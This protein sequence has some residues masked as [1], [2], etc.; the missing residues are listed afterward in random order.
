MAQAQVSKSQVPNK[1]IPESTNQGTNLERDQAGERA[2]QDPS[3][4][5]ANSGAAGATPDDIAV[6]AYQCWHER[7]CPEGSPEVD[8]HRAEQ[9]LKTSGGTSGQSRGATA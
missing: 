2:A 6:R 3:S 4:L 8:W 9:E 1:S 7:G 5:T